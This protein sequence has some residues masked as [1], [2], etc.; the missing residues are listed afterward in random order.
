MSGAHAISGLKP[1]EEG[2]S[3]GF[4]LRIVENRLMNASTISPF[5]I[6][7]RRQE[8]RVIHHRNR[9][10]DLELASTVEESS[11]GGN[12]AVGALG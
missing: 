2:V 12:S 9:G 6:L 3:H 11:Q 4:A 1:S 5:T 7:I 10:E 8:C